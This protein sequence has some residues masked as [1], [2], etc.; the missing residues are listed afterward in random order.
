MKKVKNILYD[1]IDFSIAAILLSSTAP[2][3]L[4]AIFLVK[5]DSPGPIF[6]TQIRY[7]KNKKT[8][9][10]YKFRT[11]KQNAEA[12]SPVWGREDDP[13]SSRNGKF[14]RVCHIDELPQLFNVLKGQMSIVGPRPERPYFADRFKSVIAG[15]EERHRIKPG[16]T[17]WSQINGLRANSCV[18]KRTEY[19]HFYINNR[20]LAFYFKILLLTPLAKPV[21]RE[22]PS[23]LPLDN[24]RLTFSQAAEDLVGNIPLMTPIKNA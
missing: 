3:F 11:M 24:H 17:G 12:E 8:F 20:S 16:I 19:D 1:S 22:Q 18:A 14:L 23:V 2:L 9:R 10:I 4:L 13:R 7:G 21:Q 5:L 6:Y 15:Y